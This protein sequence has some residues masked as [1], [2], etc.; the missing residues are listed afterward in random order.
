VEVVSD[1]VELEESVGVDANG[2]DVVCSIGHCV[3]SFYQLLRDPS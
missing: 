3:L 1:V 2:V